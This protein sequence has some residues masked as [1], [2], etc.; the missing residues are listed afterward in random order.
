[1][2]VII[3][4][5]SLFCFI[6]TYKPRLCVNCKYFIK[7]DD[8][9]DTGY[10]KCSKHPKEEDNNMNYLVTGIKNQNQKQYWYCSTARKYDTMCGP[11]GKDYKKDSQ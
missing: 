6:E 3:S 11:D 4:L 5:F 8:I 10:G 9:L 7:P 1:M 2:L